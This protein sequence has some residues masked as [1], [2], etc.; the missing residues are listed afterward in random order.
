[1]IYYVIN[2]KIL[3]AIIKLLNILVH[4]NKLRLILWMF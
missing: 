1:M 4:Q 3:P 2:L